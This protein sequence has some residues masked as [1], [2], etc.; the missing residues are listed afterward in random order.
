LSHE[1]AIIERLGRVFAETLHIEAPAANADLLASGIL[2][3][4]QFVTL[5]A[6]LEQHFGLHVS[7]EDVELDDLRSL[8]RIARLVA[9]DSAG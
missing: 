8:E 7:I 3:S 9:A 1:D 2:D 4:F 6:G 5:L